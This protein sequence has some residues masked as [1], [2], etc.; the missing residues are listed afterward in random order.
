MKRRENPAV[1]CRSCKYTF[2]LKGKINYCPRCKAYQLY[3]AAGDAEEAEYF[4]KASEYMSEG[5]FFNALRLYEI[6]LKNRPECYIAHFGKLCANYGVIREKEGEGEEYR[7]ACR[8]L[9]PGSVFED[10][11]YKAAL[12]GATEEER[13][14]F[15]E[16]AFLIDKEQKRLRE[17]EE[18]RH[19]E[20][21]ALY[22]DTDEATGLS[23]DYLEAKKRA[24]ERRER[25]RAEEERKRREEEAKEE[26]RRLEKQARIE[27]EKKRQKKIRALLI[28]LPCLILAALAVWFYFSYIKPSVIYNGAL[29]SI[30]S[31]NY[32]AAARTLRN[33][34]D[35]KNSAALLRKY[36]LY[37]L[38]AGDTVY[39]GK[40]EQDANAADGAEDIEWIVLTVD[41]G[42][43]LL[44]SK[45]ILDV[46]KYNEVHTS[47]TW[48][49]STLRAYLN[50]DFYNNAFNLDET[51]II[52]EV[53]NKNPD[54]TS[55]NTKGGE[56]TLD[57]VFVLSIEEA[58]KY[59]AGK[60]FAA[61]KASAYVKALGV[62]LDDKGGTY[63][64]YWWLRSS[65]IA[66]SNAAKIEFNGSISYNGAMVHYSK[67]GVR[68][69]MWV[70]VYSD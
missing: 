38:E 64:S 23:H 3:A 13:K 32:A 54:N 7:L 46:K 50:G 52:A 47:V 29:D 22:G 68:P 51:D 10:E 35:Y 24:E 16:E 12:S 61:A 67:Y 44:L 37:G 25:E 69:A 2:E 36:Q 11:D 4:V 17:K 34:G 41:D 63:N 48:E 14:A 62:Y 53:L 28:T 66:Q 58:E 1:K 56:D 33:L 45:Y 21:K 42:R 15:E 70:L 18:K 65:G 39:I 57:R 5:E 31:G 27:R 60:D 40:C 43:A 9:Q 20:N 26:R 49:N 59:I 30:E 6:I 8:R 19:E 55:M